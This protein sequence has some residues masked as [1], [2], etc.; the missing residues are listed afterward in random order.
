MKTNQRLIQEARKSGLLFILTVLLGVLGGGL[1]LVQAQKL[2][3]LVN[4]VF[5]DHLTRE[6]ITPQVLT[7]VGIFV[8]RSLITFL[9]GSAAAALSAGI[10][11]NLRSMLLTKIN[12]LGPAY[13]SGESTGEL[14]TT[15]LQGVEAL[16]AYFSQYLPQLLIA[17][18]LPLMILLVVFPL[19]TL[20]GVVFLLTAPLIPFFMSLI[21][22]ASENETRHQWQALSRLG[23]YF[24]DTLQ[25]ITTLKTLGMSRSRTS[26]IEAVS[27]QYRMT[28]LR[29]LRITFLSALALEL[30]ATISTAVV[31]VEIGLRLLYSKMIF[32]QAF[33]ILLIAPEFYQPLRQLGA[34]YHAGM[35]GVAAAQRIYQVL[36][37]PEQTETIGVVS[38]NEPKSLAGQFTLEFQNVSYSYPDRQ[39]D[40][41][42][43]VDLI[44]NSGM[45][46]GLVGRSGAGKTTLMQLLLRFIIPGDGCIIVD[47]RK[48]SSIPLLDWHRQIS[49]VP[50]RPALLDATILENIRL[51]RPDASFA[52]VRLAAAKA[53][54]DSF[55]MG[56]PHGY[57]TRIFEKAARMS[58]GEAQRIALARAFLK[59]APFLMMD[60]PTAHLDVELEEGLNESV[61]ALLQGRT[62]LIIAHRLSTLRKTDVIYLLDEGRLTASGSHTQLL[63]SSPLYRQMVRQQGEGG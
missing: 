44:I 47:G 48:L 2:S 57:E 37:T 5:L 41:L 61:Q 49:W 14:T 52:E 63:A 15:A 26:Q 3:H 20:T 30:L 31:A 39:M 38:H 55:V 13:T 28:T 11:R 10:K 7:L 54:L 9:N 36:D 24:L 42:R 53:H 6:V 21:G 29:V 22:R 56:L 4:A 8:L 59:D 40:A 25:G 58:S 50:Q 16:D 33:F 34:R 45:S 35:T 62:S 17:G 32:E 23:S 46:Y 27:E 18:L 1:I 43:N 19:D 51:A 12:R 60:E